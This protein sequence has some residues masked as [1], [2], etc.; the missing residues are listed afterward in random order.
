MAI[1]EIKK[2]PDDVLKQKA[3]PV[4]KF[5]SDLQ[6]LIDNMIETLQAAPGIGLAAPQVGVLKRLMVFDLSSQEEKYPLIVLIN[7]EVIE[8]DGI[9]E[10]E[11]GCLSIPQCVATIKR[12]EKVIVKGLDR[13]GQPVEIEGTGLLS[14]AIQ[15]EIDHLDGILLFDRVSFIK[16]EFLKKR[17]LRSLRE[18]NVGV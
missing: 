15:H 7:P 16:R 1:L 13:K 11:E 5:D 6:R 18:S 3:S 2:Y 10:S 12:A 4:E 14:R 9:I 8:T 17:Y